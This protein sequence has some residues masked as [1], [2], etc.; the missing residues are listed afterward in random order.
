MNQKEALMPPD[1]SAFRDIP[2]VDVLLQGDAFTDLLAEYGHDATRTAIR[3]ALAELRKSAAAGDIPDTSPMAIAG[4]VALSL[5]HLLAPSLVPVFNLTGTILHT[6]LGRAPLP[7]VA[8]Q[9]MINAAGAVNLE[10]DLG[11]GNRGQRDHHID[12][13]IKRLTG[14]EAA[15]AVNNNAAAV[16]MALNTLALGK[17]IIVSRGELIEIGGAFRM[18]DIM[19]RAGCVLREVGT[20]NRT[21]LKDYAGAIGPETGMILKVHTSNYAVQGF[22]KS[23]PEADLAQL[24]RDHDIPFVVDLG[25]GTLID[26]TQYGLPAE[27]T[28]RETLD[29]GADLVTFS[30]DKL[31]GGPQTGIIAG[32]ADL[33]AQLSANPMKR[34]MRLDKITIA[35][36]AAVLRL[37]ANPD[38]LAQHLPALHLL[39]RASTDIAAQADRLQP[40]IAK[41]LAHIAKVTIE[42]TQSQIGSGSLPVDRLN[43]H[44]LALTP[45]Q[46]SDK[47]L[48][49]LTDALR[50]LPRPIIGRTNNGRI[51]L[52]LR[53]LIKDD[54]FIAQFSHISIKS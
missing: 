43:S 12:G 50:R 19:Q 21:H 33:V 45:L 32:R 29:N 25:S 52:D 31:L 51:L 23:V 6:N 34:A 35:A 18:P 8:V 39:S 46:S 49:D 9:A 20:T 5:E 28:V 37:Y 14:A 54:A 47:A 15:I 42:P 27:I 53:A 17:E 7:D 16:M 48:R 40:T 10:Y 11:G 22:T 4:T 30:G 38:Q 13:W 41:T 2:S 24:A 26:L 1:Q 44:A 36:L 3:T